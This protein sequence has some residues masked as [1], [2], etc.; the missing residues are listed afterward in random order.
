MVEEWDRTIDVTLE[1]VLYGIA[2]ALPYLNDQRTGDIINAS[3]V[4]GNK[5]GPA[6][7]V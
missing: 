3:P 1:G 4:A 2:A 6:S 7:V 5:V